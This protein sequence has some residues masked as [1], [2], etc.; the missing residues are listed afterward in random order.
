MWHPWTLPWFAIRN[1]LRQPRRTTMAV[2]AVAFGVI[3]LMLASGFI[4]WIY[5]DLCESTIHSQLGHLQVVRPGFHDAGRA[6]P[7]AFLLPSDPAAIDRIR[8]V[9]G[10]AVVAPRLTFAGLASHGESTISFVGEAVDPG[11]DAKMSS[12][13]VMEKGINLRDEDPQ[14][15]IF[16]VGLARNL[17]V[18]IGDQIVLLVNTANGGINAVEL[19]LRGTFS[20]V[21][22]AYDDSA[23][24]IP[25]QTARTLLRV[26][27]AHMWTI[28]LHDTKDTDAVAKILRNTLSRPQFEVTTWYQLADFYN[29][30]VKL[31]SKQV[32][33]VWI[34]IAAIIVLGISNTLTMEVMERTNEIGTSMA[35]GAPRSRI[36]WQFVAEGAALGII[37]G[38]FGTILGFILAWMISAVGI[39]MPPPPGMAHGYIGQIRVTP[40]MASEAF[41]LAVTTTLIASIYPAWRASQ[42][43][44]VDAL[45]RNR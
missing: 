13:L 44:I 41:V 22:K 7:F 40:A 43:V 12:A 15:V 16:G 8:H 29:K 5:F 23:L 3:A 11:L 18:G 32:A 31:F 4:E 34:I 10:V 17:G 39:P 24:R 38:S 37:G 6:N 21:S 25:I 26:Q 30:T 2:G 36:L 20:T 9:P 19:T 1:L 42:Q 27:G 35:L 14:G 33:V 28:L 45:R